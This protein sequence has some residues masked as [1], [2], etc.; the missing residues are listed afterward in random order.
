IQ[1]LLPEYADTDADNENDGKLFDDI[2]TAELLT[3]T[4]YGTVTLNPD[5][6]F[7][8]T[9]DEGLMLANTTLEDDTFTYMISDGFGGTDEATVTISLTNQ[10]PVAQPDSYQTPE[11]EVLI[12]TPPLDVI[13]GH[14]VPQD[15]GDTDPDNENE[16][17]VFDDI[18]TAELIEDPTNGSVIFLE[19][20]TFVYEPDSG[21]SGEDTFTYRVTDGF[22]E[23]YSNI[24]TVTI[25]VISSPPEPGAPAAPLPDL[26]YPAIEGCPVLMQAA[27][28]ELGVTSENIQ[29]T[30][31]QALAL[32][33][34]LQPCEAC[35][36]LLRAAVILRDDAG[37]G[38][39]ALAQLL[40]PM[41]GQPITDEMVASM[42]QTISDM[43]EDPT[44]AVYVDAG[45]WND[46]LASYIGVL[47]ELG[48]DEEQIVQ[49][50]TKYTETITDGENEA[51][52]A[53]LELRLAQIMAGF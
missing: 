47:M 44:N 28:A 5:G 48:L 10:S 22:E 25:D 1:G 16:G 17:K 18:L 9:P 42:Q 50:L 40:E 2:L 20:G 29:I 49:I 4:S 19:D 46:A 7:T 26:E 24:V 8:Y 30:M 52:V 45:G 33:P 36:N 11:D 31:G 39:A 14:P 34:N 53:F 38:L 15:N 13:T 35:G 51:M 12:V 32:N 41:Q 43:R 3:D 37:E 6:S 21:F 23:S 27:A